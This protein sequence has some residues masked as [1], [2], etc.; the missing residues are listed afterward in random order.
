[1]AVNAPIKSREEFQLGSDRGPPLVYL[2]LCVGDQPPRRLHIELFHEELPTTTDNFRLLCTGELRGN[3]KVKA[4]WYKNTR[5]HRV[6]P[7]FMM[8][9]GD[10]THGNGAG[11]AAA[12]GTTFEDESFLFKHQVGAVA[13]AHQN[14]SNRSQ[15]FVCFGAPSWL[16]GKH[17]VLGQVLRDDLPHLAAF[18]AVGSASGRPLNPIVVTDAGQVGGAGFTSTPMLRS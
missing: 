1:M 9:G 16:D 8:Q 3:G 10:I 2:D 17:V 18:E 14:S 13:M 12:M 11:G 15:F 6:I 5:F 4:L 7:G